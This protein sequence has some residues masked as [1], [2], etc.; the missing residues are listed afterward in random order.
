MSIVTFAELCHVIFNKQV[1]ST[2]SKI[3]IVTGGSRGL[4][5]DVVINL[6]KTVTILF[7]YCYQNYSNN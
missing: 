5:R 2:K 4:G 3:A 1:M 7:F 6:A